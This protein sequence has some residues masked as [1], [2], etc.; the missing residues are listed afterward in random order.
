MFRQVLEVP[1]KAGRQLAWNPNGRLLALSTERQAMIL[2]T[3]TSHL[4]AMPFKVLGPWSPDGS[5]VL[6][7]P[8]LT[9]T[10][11]LRWPDLELVAKLPLQ[12]WH[13]TPNQ[14]LVAL[15]PQGIVCCN[16]PFDDLQL[17]ETGEDPWQLIRPVEEKLIGIRW[18]SSLSRNELVAWQSG[19][20]LEVA[21]RPDLSALRF[22]EWAWT[23]TN[24]AWVSLETDP[25][26]H[27][28]AWSHPL[29][30]P[31]ATVRREKV[32]GGLVHA[33]AALLWLTPTE[34][35]GWARSSQEHYSYPLPS[36]AT[37]FCRAW[38]EP[39]RRLAVSGKESLE[40][41]EVNPYG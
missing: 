7:D 25:Q 1:L 2:D 23:E 10:L 30:Q 13:W 37:A 11:V 36:D 34:V 17:L 24:D 29:G 12:R 18:R 19:F 4:Q 39:S 16:A 40:I 32:A 21:N 15:A 22:Q 28:R 14:G 31:Q 35:R 9:H 41:L 27:L 5:L 3:H 26:Q 33:G 6:A 20:P 8:D 38:H